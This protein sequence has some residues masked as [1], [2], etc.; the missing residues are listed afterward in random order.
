MGIWDAGI[1]RDPAA[2]GG[3]HDIRAIHNQEC[4]VEEP[5]MAASNSRTKWEAALQ[6]ETCDLIA[7]ARRFSVGPDGEEQAG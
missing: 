3:S 7:M 1:S 5:P 4:R 6:S 2:A